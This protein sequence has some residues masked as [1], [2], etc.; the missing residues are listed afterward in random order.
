MK[1]FFKDSG[2]TVAELPLLKERLLDPTQEF[3]FTKE[4][5][6]N[7]LYGRTALSYAERVC[8]NNVLRT[9]RQEQRAKQENDP[10][11]EQHV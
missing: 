10:I 11:L 7:R 3:H 4:Q 5:Y 9:I 1:Q 8:V 6:D 2:I